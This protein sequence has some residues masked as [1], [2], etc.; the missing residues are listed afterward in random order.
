MT[1]KITASA[2]ALSLALGTFT[3]AASAGSLAD[4]VVPETLIAQQAS[5]SINHHILPPALFVAFVAASMIFAP[6]LAPPSDARLKTDIT[7]VGTAENGLPLYHFRYVGQDQLWEGVMAQDV[8][9]HTPEAVVD[10]G[11]YYGVN[12]DMLG[13]EMRAVD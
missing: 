7:R 5:S 2:L 10:L 3:G 12:Y 1:S 11:G 6:V 9:S 4:P 8:L 13:L